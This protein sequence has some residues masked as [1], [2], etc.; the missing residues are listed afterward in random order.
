MS[1]KIRHCSPVMP[2][3]YHHPK[4]E[5]EQIWWQDRELF[6]FSFVRG[7]RLWRHY[8]IHH[9]V[10]GVQIG[11]VRWWYGRSGEFLDEDK[12]DFNGP[13]KE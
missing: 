12:K 11:Y 10:T 2:I 7:S 1:Y 13:D 6:V 5:F 3:F 8:I 4:N 9:P